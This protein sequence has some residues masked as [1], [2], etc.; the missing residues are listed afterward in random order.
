MRAR[1]DDPG[2]SE[3]EELYSAVFPLSS[4]P[5]V[6][7]KKVKEDTKKWRR[8]RRLSPPLQPSGGVSPPLHT[9]KKNPEQREDSPTR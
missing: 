9:H 3:D 7:Q 1:R 6:K 8:E 4:S 2:R 5:R